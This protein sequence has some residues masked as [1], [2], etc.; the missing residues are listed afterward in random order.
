MIRYALHC[1][2]GHEFEAWF[3]SSAD[4][5]RTAAAGE[6]TCPFCG[7]TFVEKALMAPAVGGRAHPHEARNQGRAEESRVEEGKSEKVA[8]AAPDPRQAAFREAL[9]E[10][11]RKLTENADYVGDRFAEEARKIHYSEVEP[12]GIYGEATAE[13]AEGLAEEG[14]AFQPLPPLPE[15]RN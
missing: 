12:H 7:S 5:E 8:L 14:V 15:D 1:D 11:R 2:R 10:F 3:G 6:N 13:E 4:Y 9:K